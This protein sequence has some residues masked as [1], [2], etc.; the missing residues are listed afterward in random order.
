MKNKSII[1]KKLMPYLLVMAFVISLFINPVFSVNAEA[2]NK[3]V[4]VV[5]DPGHGGT[6]DRNLGAQYNGLSE[7]ELTLQLANI[8]KA[9]LEIRNMGLTSSDVAVAEAVLDLSFT[10]IGKP[11]V[12][13]TS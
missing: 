13:I 4:V 8:L 3:N 1:A 10:I 7:K 5:I 9:E 12:T 6:G 11:I 2:A